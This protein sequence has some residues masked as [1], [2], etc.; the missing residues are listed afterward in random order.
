[1]PQ[2][3]ST[4]P[5]DSGRSGPVGPSWARPPVSNEAPPWSGTQDAAPW[6]T[7]PQHA[8]AA[9]WTTNMPATPPPDVRVEPPRPESSYPWALWRILIVA[10]PVAGVLSALYGL[11][12]VMPRRGIFA[13]LDT[14]PASVTRNAAAVSDTI[15]L[16]LFIAAGAGVV[17]AGVLLTMW[18][19]RARRSAAGV[20]S[21][22]GLVWRVVT[23]A[24]FALVLVAL[25]LHMT[26]DASQIALG[27]VI[28]GVGAFL[29][30]LGAFW[31][32]TGVRQSGREAA[33]IV[34]RPAVPATPRPYD[35]L[36]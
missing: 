15:N 12:A 20:S 25:L 9:N 21:G 30:A 3:G 4:E 18:L 5:P 22:L 24:G 31:A 23:G 32:V 13:E 19:V 1:M 28:L 14:M 33:L 11:F 6:Q 16:V 36:Q 2:S 10:L 26:T 34:A 27:Y 17:A 8:G 7:P 29:L 35:S